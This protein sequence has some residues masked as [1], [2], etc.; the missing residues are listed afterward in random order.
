[1]HV[2]SSQSNTATQ[3]DNKTHTQCTAAAARILVVRA[4]LQRDML[5]V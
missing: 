5:L 3:T 1:M 2:S 4:G